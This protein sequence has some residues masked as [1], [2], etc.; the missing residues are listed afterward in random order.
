[1]GDKIETRKHPRHGTQ[2]LI[3]S[4]TNRNPAQSIKENAITVFGPRLHNCLS[5]CQ[6]IRETAK[7]LK[8]KNLNV[9]STNFYSLFLMSPKYPTV[10]P[11]QEAT[12]SSA[13]YVIVGL[14][15]LPKVVESPTRPRSRLSYFETTRSNSFTLID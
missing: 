12:A 8:L 6:N 15:E 14:K 9:G 3:Q 2:C 4:P 7:V 10:I 11:Q 1:M 13:S 5:D